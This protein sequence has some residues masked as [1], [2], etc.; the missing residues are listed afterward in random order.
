MKPPFEYRI[1]ILILTGGCLPVLITQ[2]LAWSLDL[3]WLRAAEL[4]F[5][6]CIPVAIWMAAKIN[7]RWHDDRED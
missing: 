2:F 7:E 3:S 5:I 6:V 1:A 4:T